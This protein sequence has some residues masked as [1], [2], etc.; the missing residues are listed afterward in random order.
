MFVRLEWSNTALR[1]FCDA[2]V[3]ELPPE[4]VR[5]LPHAVD[6]LSR[7]VGLESVAVPERNVL[8]PLWEYSLRHTTGT[9]RGQVALVSEF[10]ALAT[11]AKSAGYTSV[12]PDRLKSVVAQQAAQAGWSLLNNCASRILARTH[13]T[14]AAESGTSADRLF[15][16]L[17]AGWLS[18]FSSDLVTRKEFFS[19]ATYPLDMSPLDLLEVLWSSKLLGVASFDAEGSSDPD[20]RVVFSSEVPTSPLA[21][22]ATTFVLHSALIDVI[23]LKPAPVG[24]RIIFGDGG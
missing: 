3:G 12:R 10:L 5:L 21:G 9:P 22:D 7:V 18:E 24:F 4:D 2:L 8:E 13:R 23:H 15:V 16:N 17:L 1:G 11:H 19:R 14:D 6:P 20:P